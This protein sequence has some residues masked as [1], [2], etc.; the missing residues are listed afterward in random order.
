[1]SENVPNTA[2]LSNEEE[3]SVFS[4][5]DRVIRFRAPY[6][7]ERYTEIREWDNGY[8]VVMAKYRHNQEP[9]EEYIDLVPILEALYMDAEEFL[10]PIK[11]VAIANA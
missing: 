3:F 1:M 9:E 11:G 2:F 4:Y 8:L 7:L 6:S 10:T 5:N